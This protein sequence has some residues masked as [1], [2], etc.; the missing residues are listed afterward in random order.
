MFLY[1]IE[2]IDIEDIREAIQNNKFPPECLENS[3]A[4]GIIYDS[5]MEWRSLY[6]TWHMAY[7]P[8]LNEWN[9]LFVKWTP[10]I[11]ER[12]RSIYIH[13]RPPECVFRNKAARPHTF[14][15]ELWPHQHKY[16]PT[17]TNTCHFVDWAAPSAARS[18]PPKTLSMFRDIDIPGTACAPPSATLCTPFVAKRCCY[19]IWI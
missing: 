15:R 19:Y 2:Y 3:G 12:M 16:I 11:Q 7:C 17:A 4:L 1:N 14:T 8:Y 9:S 10:S 6:A 5:S 13:L 18:Q